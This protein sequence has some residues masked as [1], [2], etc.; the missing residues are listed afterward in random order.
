MAEDLKSLGADQQD[1]LQEVVNIA[2]GQAGEMLA[3][4]LDA[5]LA[6]S[7]PRARVV[8]AAEAARHIAAMVDIRGEATV[9]RQ[10]FQDRLRGEAMVVFGPDGCHNLA[11]LLGY[12]GV[13]DAA[14]ER[15]L[16]L[17][18]ANILVGAV[19]NGVG[20]QVGWAFRVRPPELL[21]GPLDLLMN[22]S[23]LNW[24][25]ALLV[26][27]NFSLTDRGFRCHLILLMPERSIDEVRRALDRL[28]A[29]L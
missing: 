13:P 26:E 19:L 14:A 17:D 24:R 15:E 23:R 29:E 3:R 10:S 18:V 28:L 4:L 5:Q 21:G 2:M 27:V 1:A 7:V 16:V 20:D 6:L 22:P 25:H 11:D 12:N 9:V 8:V